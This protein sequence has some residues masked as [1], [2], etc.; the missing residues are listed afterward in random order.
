MLYLL[1]TALPFPV[2]ESPHAHDLTLGCIVYATLADGLGTGSSSMG[3]WS[4][5]ESWCGGILGT[6]PPSIVEAELF[7]QG[8]NQDKVRDWS[9]HDLEATFALLDTNGDGI[10][11]LGEPTRQA[12]AGEA[13]VLAQAFVRRTARL[14][15][16]EN[17]D[18]DHDG[19]VSQSERAAVMKEWSDAEYK[20]KLVRRWIEAA[21]QEPVGRWSAISPGASMAA[22]GANLDQDQDGHRIDWLRME[23]WFYFRDR[24]GDKVLDAS[25][26]F[27]PGLRESS[28][29]LDPKLSP[30]IVPRVQALA[31]ANGASKS[32]RQGDVDGAVQR[33]IGLAWLSP[34]AL[35]VPG[36]ENVTPLETARMLLLVALPSESQPLLSAFRLLG[37]SLD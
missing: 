28:T 5:L 23:D 8:V 19:R 36:P 2:Q 15:L 20:S 7:L 31:L 25:E 33:L 34:E 12:L 6:P 24:D 13:P 14:L 30:P 1:L 9:V 10:I 35:D 32:L 37:V 4:S 26:L 18:G 21:K 3:D 22:F 17:A 16:L 27:A 11:E 29:D